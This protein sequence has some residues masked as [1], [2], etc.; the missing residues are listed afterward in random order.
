M[1]TRYKRSLAEIG[2]TVFYD[3]TDFNELNVL[4]ESSPKRHGAVH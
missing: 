1:D 2:S 4:S 3:P